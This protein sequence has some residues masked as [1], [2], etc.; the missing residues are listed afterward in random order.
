MP[1]QCVEWGA[2][3]GCAQGNIRVGQADCMQSVRLFRLSLQKSLKIEHTEC[4]PLVILMSYICI[5]SPLL[6]P[7]IAVAICAHAA[8]SDTCHLTEESHGHPHQRP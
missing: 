3:Q 4:Y 1:P 5:R 6:I 7:C 8:V 2:G